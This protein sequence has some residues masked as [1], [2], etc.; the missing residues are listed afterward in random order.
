MQHGSTIPTTGALM[1]VSVD[2]FMKA[3]LQKVHLTY[4][5]IISTICIA[6]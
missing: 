4:V 1:Y 5:A 2:V 6:K 3:K